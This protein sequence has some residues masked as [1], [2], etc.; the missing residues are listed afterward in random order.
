MLM[1]HRFE[2]GDLLNMTQN[3]CEPVMT[4]KSFIGFMHKVLKGSKV[5]YGGTWTAPK[6]STVV[7]VPIGYADGIPRSLSNKGKVLIRGEL[8]PIVGIVCMDYLM[9]DVSSLVEK[10]IGPVIGDEVVFLGKQHEKNI[11]AE[12]LADWAGT[13]SYEIMTGIQS[14]L[15]RVYVH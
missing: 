14:R 10:G 12:D 3:W 2:A 9:V 4:V 13:I 7:V 8:C 15:A 11:R 1:Q 5:S 6:D